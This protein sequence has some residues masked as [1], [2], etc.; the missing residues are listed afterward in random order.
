MAKIYPGIKEWV[1][2]KITSPTDRV[3]I[4]VTG[5]PKRRQRDYSNLKMGNQVALKSSVSKYGWDSHRFEI[6]DRFESDENYALGKE[7]FWIRSWMSNV[8][9]Y[10]EQGGLNMTDGGRGHLGKPMSD[11]TKEKL[12]QAN[13]GKKYS[14]ETKRKLSEMRKGKKIKSGWTEEKKKA[15]SERIKGFKH[16]DEAKRK[17]S[18]TSIGNKYNLGRKHTAE[19]IAKRK[20]AL[21]CSIGKSILQFDLNGVLL[22][23]FNSISEVM[24]TMGVSRW[25]V[26]RA[27]TQPN[28]DNFLN[29]YLFKYK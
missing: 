28:N 3:Y 1:I 11:E 22:N 27:I 20:D 4:G 26:N 7:M 13:L 23:E 19:E 12:R 21:R 5:D 16:T 17:I 24:E 29:K 6:I 10:P 14:D 8:G 9:K 18:E 25:I 2:Y 15:Q